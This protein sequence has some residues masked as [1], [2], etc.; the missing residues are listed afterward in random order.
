MWQ[1]LLMRLFVIIASVVSIGGYFW[2][3]FAPPAGLKVTRDGVPYFAPPVLH[4][5]TGEA[6]PLETLVRHYKG[7]K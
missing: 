6:I 4:P 3:V 7:E 1:R 5:I 2:M